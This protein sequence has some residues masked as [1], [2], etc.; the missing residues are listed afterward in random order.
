MRLL[1][2]DYGI[3]R[4][5]LAISDEGGKLAFPKS[6]I[7]NGPG[8]FRVLAEAI[9]EEN[10]SEIVVGE[11]MDAKGEENKVMIEIK[12][13]AAELKKRFSLPVHFQKEFF[14][15]VEA[16]G[17]GGKETLNDR[18]VSVPAQSPADAKAAALI[19]Q[20]Y[21]DRRNKLIKN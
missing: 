14:T 9:K 8:V 5:G 1:G 12:K 3:K 6:I 10:I 7:P 11:S 2:I 4:I 18:K 13:F 15:T 20:R 17:R 19:L 21:L 16:R